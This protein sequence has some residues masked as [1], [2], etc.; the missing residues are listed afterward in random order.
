MRELTGEKVIVVGAG[1]AGLTAAFRLK[2]RGCDVTVLERN[3]HVGGRMS[4]VK[5]GG[6]LVDFA[7]SILPTSYT[8]MA[9]LIADAGLSSQVQPTNDLIGVLRDGEIHRLHGLGPMEV[10]KTRLLGMRSKLSLARAFLDVRGYRNPAYWQDLSLAYSSDTESAAEYARRLLPEEVID[11]LVDPLC[12]DLFLA[13]A[14]EVS[15]VDFLFLLGAMM[16]TSFF[17]SSRGI[18]F[19][20]E[21]LAAQLDV[22]TSAT[23]NA[24][25]EHPTGVTVEWTR[26]GEAAQVEHASAVVVAVPA[27]HVP[28]ICPQLSREQIGF[29]NSV[30]YARSLV[31]SFGLPRRP[32]EPAMWLHL[33]GGK[34]ATDLICL[35]LEHNKA[36]GRVP[37][38]HGM[39]TTYWVQSWSQSRW[40]DDDEQ[41]GKVAVGAVEAVL[42]D[43]SDDVDMMYV[44]RVNP[45]VAVRPVGGLRALRDFV[46][47]FSPHSRIQLAGDYFSSSCTNASLCSGEAAA[48]SIAVRL[49]GK[50]AAA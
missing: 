48:S 28:R 16:G 15:K 2:Q 49:A 47:S 9:G 1:I 17:N 23:V 42:P 50:S 45:G 20:A 41:I 30:F 26:D 33:P 7:A 19:L 24:V 11:Y 36:P 35:I 29:L 14:N 37:E 3:D 44:R 32:A 43:M 4:T 34:K 13:G 38:G 40:D 6:Y 39:V 18:S 10:V 5:R 12:R 22:R 21:G 27:T 31:V 8:Q 46:S 25:V